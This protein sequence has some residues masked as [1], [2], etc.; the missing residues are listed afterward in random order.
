M[1]PSPVPVIG[2]VAA[3][4]TGKTTL[5]KSL[6]PVLRERGLRLGYLKHAHHSFDLDRPGKDSFEIREAG[7]EQTLLASSER[8]AL[9]SAQRETSRDPSLDEMVARFDADALDLILVEGFKFASYPK[10]E[11]HRTALGRPLLYPDDADI[12]AVISDHRLPGDDHPP[13]L[14]PQDP[15]AIADFILD[16]VATAIPSGSRLREELPR[17]YRLLHIHGCND[18]HSGNASV[19]DGDGLWITPAGACADTLTPQGLVFC[20]PE[21]ECPEGASSDA[22]LHRLVYRHQP[23][24]RAVLH[25]HGPYSVA[26]S[27]AGQDYRPADFEAQHY[28]ESVPV[29]NVAYENYAAEA[30]QMVAE[31]LAEHPVC[32][33][34]G[35]GVYAWG[36]SIGQAYKWTTTLE[37]SA[38]TFVIARQAASV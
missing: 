18:S 31:A 5:L 7:A 32:M 20:P 34:R 11:L 25:S 37:L 21:G 28:F 19:R 2:L 12:V 38:K 3:S 35:H 6:V 15:Q 9:Q 17:Y 29:L 1:R 23:A 4:G 13:V 26:M 24:A 36:D 22:Q 10:I 16:Y 33:V 30:P 8:W 27:F 14:P